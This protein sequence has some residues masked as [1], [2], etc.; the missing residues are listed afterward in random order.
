MSVLSG[1]RSKIEW[2]Y[3]TVTNYL[4]GIS[5]SDKKLASVAQQVI[6]AKEGIVSA[7]LAN[8]KKRFHPLTGSCAPQLIHDFF[9]CAFVIFTTMQVALPKISSLT[10]FAI[11]SSAFGFVGSALNI[12]VGVVTIR[13]AINCFRNG[14]TAKGIRLLI[15]GLG[16]VMLGVFM[17]LTSI[18]AVASLG[19]MAAFFAANPWIMPILLLVFMLPLLQEVLKDFVA[20]CRKEDPYSKMQLGQMQNLLE[21]DIINWKEVRRCLEDSE[22]NVETIQKESNSTK[23]LVDCVEKLQKQMGPEGAVNAMKV[24]K[25]ILE[26]D[27]DEAIKQVK[28]LRGKASSWKRVQYTRLAQQI[29]F[30]ASFILSIVALKSPKAK[31]FEAVDNGLAFGGMGIPLVLDGYFPFL[32]NVPIIV[33]ALKE[34]DLKEA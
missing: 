32:R 11:A 30:I 6:T 25:A 27:K 14:D 31:I 2:G 16:L 26:E 18:A 13:E 19:G 28:S 15:C 1:I 23:A 21:K 34:E 8:K 12:I 24:L 20:I 29:L 5:S 7:S 10:P 33:P 4:P 9:N 22:L 3:E 17:A